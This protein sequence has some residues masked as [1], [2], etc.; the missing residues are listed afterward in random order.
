MVCFGIKSIVV[1]VETDDD[2]DIVFLGKVDDPICGGDG[3]AEGLFSKETN[4]VLAV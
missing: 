2:A 4:E 3:M 1:I